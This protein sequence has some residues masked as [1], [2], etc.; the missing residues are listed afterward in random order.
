MSLPDAEAHSAGD[1]GNLEPRRASLRK[2][3]ISAPSSL[4]VSII[5]NLDGM[6][7]KASTHQEGVLFSSESSSTSTLEGSD[8]QVDFGAH[9][10]VKGAFLLCQPQLFAKKS[11]FASTA[12]LSLLPGEPL[13]L[14]HPMMDASKTSCAGF[15]GQALL[16]EEKVPVETAMTAEEELA[17]SRQ[18]RSAKKASA[19]AEAKGM[20][21]RMAPKQMQT[22]SS[23]KKCPHRERAPSA[24][25]K[26]RSVCLDVKPSEGFLEAQLRKTKKARCV[27]CMIATSK[28][29][30]TAFYEG[31]TWAIADPEAQ[32]KRDEARALRSLLA[33]SATSAQHFLTPRR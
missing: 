17:L 9:E 12:H 5:T 10:A 31:Q 22:L 28:E 26:K 23:E 14:E 1:A 16:R 29:D 13:K 33:A 27:N 30:M 3:A 24:K 11:W 8:A 15:C 20:K 18:I 32:S 7:C 25:P 19:I 4:F 21:K 2:Q 6:E